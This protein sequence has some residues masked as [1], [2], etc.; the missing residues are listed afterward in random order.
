MSINSIIAN[1]M[2]LV[3]RA[4][5]VAKKCTLMVPQRFYNPAYPAKWDDLSPQCKSCKCTYEPVHTII[6]HGNFD[7]IKKVQQCCKFDFFAHQLDN[8]GRVPLHYAKS[9]FAARILLSITADVI[10]IQDKHGDTPLNICP[11]SVV[12]ILLKHGADVHSVKNVQEVNGY[13]QH[14]TV[15]Q[16]TIERGDVAK[17]R[18][19]LKH[20][21][22]IKDYEDFGKLKERAYLRFERTQDL[23]THDITIEYLYAAAFGDR[24]HI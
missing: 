6:E 5:N 2:H 14:Y 22:A 20:Q 4:I 18:L 17:L 13:Q 16:D 8:K 15:I 3:R 19:F 23:T 24:Y 9:E 10:N 12:P 11:A 7:D 21:D 1:A